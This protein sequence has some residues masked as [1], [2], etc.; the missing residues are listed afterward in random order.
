MNSTPPPS[1]GCLTSSGGGFTLV[2][3]LVVITI[4][5]VLASLLLPTLSGAKA[6]ARSTLCLNHLKQ[7]GLATLLYADDHAHQVILQYPTQPRH[8]WGTALSTNQYVTVSN[9]FLCPA[10]P[11][12]EFKDWRRIY[13]IRM[14]PPSECTRGEFEEVLRVD[15]VI[16]PATYL[17][18]ADT[19]SRGRGGFQAQQY[20]YFRV[21]SEKEVHARHWGAASGFFLDG[22]VQRVRGKALEDFGVR[23]LC[24]PDLVPG[25]W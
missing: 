20:F 8:T 14:D 10:Y 6:K 17:H 16:C 25:Y 4:I 12:K 22:H 3:L 5:A 21:R 7:V 11:P 24:G 19:T 1:A 13:G 23:A 2:E 9:V 15:R 18:L